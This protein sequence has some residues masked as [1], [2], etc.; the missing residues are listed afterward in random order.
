MNTVTISLE[1]YEA[2][3]MEIAEL[4][5]EVREKTIYKE[6]PGWERLVLKAI[7]SLGIIALVVL[8]I[9]MALIGL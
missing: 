2:M 9:S 1:V 5:A 8:I 4:K 3:K 7:V 6:H